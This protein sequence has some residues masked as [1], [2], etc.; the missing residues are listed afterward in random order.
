MLANGKN[1]KTPITRG[2]CNFRN[3]KNLAFAARVIW[4]REAHH[5][6]VVH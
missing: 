4:D 5:L 2:G 6:A 1:R 3:G